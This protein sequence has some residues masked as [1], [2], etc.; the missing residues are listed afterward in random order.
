MSAQVPAPSQ[1]SW[2]AHSEAGVPQCAPAAANTHPAVQHSPPSQSSPG[3]M[4]PFPQSGSV[5]V[6]VVLDDVDVEEL[7]DVELELEVDEVVVELVLVDDVVVVG[8]GAEMVAHR[9][10]G[11]LWPSPVTNWVVAVPDCDR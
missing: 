3:S 8:G 9:Q 4:P 7:V 10:A 11:L 5:E 2:L 6:V 1:V